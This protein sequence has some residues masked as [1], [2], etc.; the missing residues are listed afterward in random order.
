MDSAFHGCRHVLEGSS[1]GLIDR[2][3]GLRVVDI[4]AEQTGMRGPL[5]NPEKYVDMNYLRQ[6]SKELG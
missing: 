4:Y 2:W 3:Q 1:N 6:P 5:P